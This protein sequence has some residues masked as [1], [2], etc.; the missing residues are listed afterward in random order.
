M[1]DDCD[2]FLKLPVNSSWCHSHTYT[3]S[4]LSLRSHNI[5]SVF[6]LISERTRYISPFKSLQ[7]FLSLINFEI[8]PFTLIPGY[9]NYY[10]IV[11][12]LFGEQS[13]SE[14]CKMLRSTHSNPLSS[15]LLFP[16]YRVKYNAFTFI[17]HYW[18]RKRR[19]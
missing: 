15:Y 13:R 2:S 9:L 1:A 16:L 8:P 19:T 18:P 4:A 3:N 17:Q 6:I 5:S 11:V 7:L 14:A 12:R 10:P